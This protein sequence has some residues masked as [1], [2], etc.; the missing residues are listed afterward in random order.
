MNSHSPA[1]MGKILQGLTIPPC[2][3]ILTEVQREVLKPD[4]NS[5][6]VVDLISRDVALAASIIKIANSP[7]F[8]LP[9]RVSSIALA[10][11]LLGSR[12]LINF[13]INEFLKRSFTDKSGISMER[14]WD[15]AARNA[16]VCSLLSAR[17][18]GTDRE[19]A[20]CFGLFHDC[21]IPLMMQRYP[22]YKDTLRLANN[23]S[24]AFLAQEEARHGTSHAVMGYLLARSWGLSDTLCEAIRSHHDYAALDPSHDLGISDEACTLIAISLLGE[25]IVGAFLRQPEEAE[26]ERGRGAIQSFF[27]LQ[28]TDL[29][30]II[31]D[32]LERMNR[33][34]D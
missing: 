31:E 11:P 28:A 23:G 1:E 13:V 6:R 25:H 21:G 5:Q 15:R 29:D 3:A 34:A 12:Q 22:D 16:T 10:L 9:Q 17:L 4:F 18:P 14:F 7:V 19:T 26:W 8:G 27:G 20:Y 32:Q 33:K 2:P 30:D 24:S